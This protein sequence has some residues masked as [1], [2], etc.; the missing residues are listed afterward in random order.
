M[1][2]HIDRRWAGIMLCSFRTKHDTI[3]PPLARAPGWDVLEQSALA[4]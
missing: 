3:C 4:L 1:A 2:R